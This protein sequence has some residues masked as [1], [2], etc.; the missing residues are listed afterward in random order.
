MTLDKWREF[1]RCLSNVEETAPIRV[2]DKNFP[3]WILGA[4]KYAAS[5][6]QALTSNDFQVEGFL[7]TA[8]TTPTYLG[9]PVRSLANGPDNRDALQLAIGIFNRET[10]FAHLEAT[11]KSHGYTKI[12]LPNQLYPQLRAELGW[13]YWM[14]SRSEITDH[15]SAFAETY[16]KLSDEQSRDR[17]IGIL[18]FRLG[19]DPE[20]AN[21]RD[22]DAQYFNA[23]TMPFLNKKN[24]IS[25]V[26]GGAFDGDSYRYLMSV[27]NLSEAYLFE[28][29]PANYALLAENVKGKATGVH[30][31]PMALSDS[32][33]ILSFGGGT[34]ESSA[35]NEN[36]THSILAASLDDILPNRT[37]DFLKLDIEGAESAALEGARFLLQRSQPVVALSLYHKV[38]DLAELP[39]LVNAILPD[40]KLHIL[41]HMYNS[42]E[43]VLYAIPPD[44]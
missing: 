31:L 3:I 11:A 34:G 16:L 40:H 10:S 2:L 20:Y 23:L 35:I 37:I 15:I 44:R 32:H 19:I 7:A 28:P 1:E 4:G 42:F 9:L 41:Q 27:G 38:K 12:F 6:H 29:D 14:S 24:G 26:D 30:C 22:E 43:S 39:K 18:K 33:K 21:F 13:R 36:G 25:Y 8:P 17:Y 5:L